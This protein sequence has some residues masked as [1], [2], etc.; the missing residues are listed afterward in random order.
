MPDQFFYDV[1]LSHFSKD[2]AVV[3]P[4]AER[5]WADNV[6]VLLDEWEIK[7]GKQ[8]PGT[9]SSRREPAQTSEQPGESMSGLTS[10]ATRDEKIEERLERSSVQT[11]PAKAPTRRRKSGTCGRRNVRFRD[12][13]NKERRRPHQELAARFLYIKWLPSD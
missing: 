11:C 4:L 12:P 7:A 9:G 8:P 3:R 10:A 13:L 6:K 5:L 2:K 1:F